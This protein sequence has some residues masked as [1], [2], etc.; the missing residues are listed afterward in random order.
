VPVLG[1]ESAPLAW[2]VLTGAGDEAE[3]GIVRWDG[4]AGGIHAGGIHAGLVA[5]EASDANEV[6]LVG[7]VSRALEGLGLD[8][9]R[10]V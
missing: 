7:A 6:V 4:V 5:V 2:D 1:G 8:Y 3:V 9:M 10:R